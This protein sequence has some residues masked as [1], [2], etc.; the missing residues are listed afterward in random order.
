MIT[1]H[2]KPGNAAI[3]A[4]KITLKIP[5]GWKTYTPIPAPTIASAQEA[6]TS[7]DV[8][9]SKWEGFKKMLS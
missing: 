5:N 4:I 3:K 7:K 2:S 8:K 6:P 9:D 1:T